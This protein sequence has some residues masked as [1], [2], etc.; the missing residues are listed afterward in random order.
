MAR[1][2]RRT[3]FPWKTPPRA[4]R[5][6]EAFER[7]QGAIAAVKDFDER[8]RVRRAWDDFLIEIDDINAEIE[9]A[10]AAENKP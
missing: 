5:V 10:E 3:P 6:L 1:T 2:T 8:A 4:H 9:A 7:F